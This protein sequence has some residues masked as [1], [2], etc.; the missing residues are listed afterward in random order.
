MRALSSRPVVGAVL[1]L[2]AGALVVGAM[3][4]AWGGN[5]S[6]FLDVQARRTWAS[7]ADARPISPYLGIPGELQPTAPFARSY[8]DSTQGRS[9]C[10]A[11]LYYPDEVVEEGVLQTTGQYENTTLARSHNPDIGRGTSQTVAPLGAPGP[12]ATTT[13]PSRTACTSE[14]VNGAGQDAVV[15]DLGYARTSTD[16]DG[17]K[18]LVDEAV[19]RAQG[20]TAGPVRIAN[21]ETRLKLE[22]RLGAEP[23]VSYAMTLAGVEV[24]GAPVLGLGD[25]GVTLAGQQVAGREVIDQF[26]GEVNK[27]GAV[28][29]EQ[30]FSDY[31]HLVQPDVQR[32]YDGGA[33]VTGPALDI[34]QKNKFRENTQGDHFGVRLGYA[35]VYATVTSLEVEGGDVPPV[36]DLSTGA[37]LGSPAEPTP[38][39]AT[40]PPSASLTADGDLGGGGAAGVPA[41]DEVLA[42]DAGGAGSGDPVELAG[43]GGSAGAGYESAAGVADAGT[44]AGTVSE[45]AGA[46]GSAAGAATPAAG[47]P[48][49][50]VLGM[51]RAARDTANGFLG[52]IA[53]LLAALVVVGALSLRR[54]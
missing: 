8:L 13:N 6:N 48:T 34:G 46:A 43:S 23:L 19:S 5:D 40:A 39:S 31:I 33:T 11:A 35:Q 29:G 38:A 10:F 7:H 18:V 41:T 37:N 27:N 49:P 15:A 42:G 44:G 17:D 47:T 2:C 53:V 51:V 24:N 1:V 4:A 25:K 36:P 54:A 9:E 21:F 52:G 12:R 32:E 20:V 22:Y 3:P 16:F 28:L 26:Q 30:A 14:A 50:A 45:A